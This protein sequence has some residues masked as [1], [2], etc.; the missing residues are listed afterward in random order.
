M[1]QTTQ[2]NS[3]KLLISLLVLV[4]GGVGFWYLKTTKPQSEPIQ[5]KEKAWIIS[6]V[7]VIPKTLTPTLTLYGRVESPRNAVLRAPNLTLSANTEVI[8]VAILEGE[9]VKK[10][11]LLVQLDDRDSQLNLTQRKA[12]ITDI[13]AQISVEKQRNENNLAAITHDE[14]LLKL[15]RE[16]VKRAEQLKQ[17]RVGSQAALEDTQQAVERQMLTVVNRRTEIKMYQARLA[18]L[19]AKQVRAVALRDAAQ[20][21]L[22]R[23]KI[24]APFSG[25]ISDVSVSVGDRVR[26]GDALLTVYDNTALEVRAQIPNLYAGMVLRTLTSG[27]TLAASAE[28]N[29]QR[30]LLGL[31]RVSGQ[32]SRNSG[33]IDG[34]FLVIKGAN[35]LRLGQFI[36]L[37]L[38][39][40]AQAQ[41]VALPFSAMYGKDRIYKLVAERMQGLTVERVGEYVESTEDVKMLVRSLQLN[42]GDRI[43]TTQLPNAIEGLRVQ[44]AE[45]T[46]HDSK[47]Q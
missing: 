30:I 16:S 14:T 26:S 23:T 35:A 44:V 20:L 39:L 45:E 40:P 37:F 27:Q 21:E 17:Q 41:V 12:D 5:A 18:Q 31:D 43:I 42:A 3:S 25:I 24:L 1:M 34:L 33:G 36:T 11:Q 10:G 32:I 46:A 6:T 8:V 15:V 9:Q 47:N 13:E 38:D 22:E 29:A 7:S 19:E 28:V 4:I 2:K